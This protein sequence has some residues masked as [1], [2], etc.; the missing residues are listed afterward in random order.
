MKKPMDRH[1]LSNARSAYLHLDKVVSIDHK[2]S[3]KMINSKYI[4]LLG[5]NEDVIE[6]L[7]VE[8]RII[9]YQNEVLTTGILLNI[10]NINLKEESE[11]KVLELIKEESKRIVKQIKAYRSGK[12]KAY[13]YEELK[14]L[15]EGKADEEFMEK[16]YDTHYPDRKDKKEDV[17]VIKNTR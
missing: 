7:D 4:F 15:A 14:S 11:D 17:E 12:V 10:I 9:A 8:K 1:F 3:A 5:L 13:T 16:I 6:S 2:L